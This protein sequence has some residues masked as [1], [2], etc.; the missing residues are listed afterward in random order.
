MRGRF[1]WMV[2]FRFKLIVLVVGKV[3]KRP[4]GWGRRH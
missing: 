4:R 2:I 3:W 1:L